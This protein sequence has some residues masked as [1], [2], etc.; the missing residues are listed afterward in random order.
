[1]DEYNII[2]EEVS[3]KPVNTFGI[4][5]QDYE[6]DFMKDNTKYKIID[7]PQ[8]FQIELTDKATD[9]DK[10]DYIEYVLSYVGLEYKDFFYEEDFDPDEETDYE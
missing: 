6:P 7:K 1:M 5:E 4:Y 8:T 3:R 9:K 10:K 2:L